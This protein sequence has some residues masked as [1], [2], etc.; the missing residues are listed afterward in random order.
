MESVEIFVNKYV[1][2]AKTSKSGREVKVALIDDGVDANIEELK[3][4]ISKKGW[5]QEG[6]TSTNPP[7]YHSATRHGTEMAKLILSVCP[8]VQLCV[9][10]LGAW[11][12]KEQRID[13]LGGRSTAKDA[14]DVS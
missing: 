13:A 7:F 10:K 5:P 3:G 2:I 12:D 8:H 4:H 9:A 6:P 1:K 14:A 11:T